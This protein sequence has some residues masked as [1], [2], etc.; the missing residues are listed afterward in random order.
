VTRTKKE[1]SIPLKKR[2]SPKTSEVVNQKYLVP[3]NRGDNEE[4]FPLD[5]KK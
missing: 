5:E 2:D 4:D 1:Y 3:S